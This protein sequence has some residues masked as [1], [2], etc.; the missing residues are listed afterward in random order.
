MSLKEKISGIF[1][2]EKAWDNG[3]DDDDLSESS[4]AEYFSYGIMIL[5]GLIAGFFGCQ[6]GKY[7]HQQF[8]CKSWGIPFTSRP[9]G[10][11]SPMELVVDIVAYGIIYGLLAGIGVL[12]NTLVHSLFEK[13]MG[14][15]SKEVRQTALMCGFF[16]L[17]VSTV[18]MAFV[19]WNIFFIGVP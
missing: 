18:I 1:H 5:Y 4:V 10:Y 9:V 11:Y 2:K 8:A 6:Y 16:A 17:I 13:Q 19:R 15:Q 7:L 12:V 14:R 3:S